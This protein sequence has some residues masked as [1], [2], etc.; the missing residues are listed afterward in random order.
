MRTRIAILSIIISAESVA[1]YAAEKLQINPSAQAQAIEDAR[2][3]VPDTLSLDFSNVKEIYLDEYKILNDFEDGMLCIQDVVTGKCGFLNTE[4]EWAIPVSLQLASF[5]PERT[6]VFRNGYSVLELSQSSQIVVIDQNGQQT[7]LPKSIVQCSDFTPEGYALAVKTFPVDKY[8]SKKKLVFIN[9]QGQEILTG[10]Y[11]GNQYLQ[12]E[13]EISTGYQLEPKPRRDEMIEEGWNSSIVSAYP[14]SDGLSPYYDYISKLWGFF[15]STGK[16]VIPAKYKHV[17]EFSEGLAAVQMPTESD[18]PEKWGFINTADQMVIAPRFSIEP[19]DFSY[20]FARVRKVNKNYVYIDKKGNVVS[21]EYDRANDFY[22]GYAFVRDP[23]TWT[24]CCINTNFEIVNTGDECGLQ[25]D[26]YFWRGRQIKTYSSR[27]G[28]YDFIGRKT[29][30]SD[31]KYKAISGD[32]QNIFITSGPMLEIS[33][34]TFRAYAN[35]NGKVKFA[36]FRNEF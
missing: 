21:P 26:E 25:D 2:K 20:G 16:K 15:D 19:G 10:V 34:N 11:A 29:A 33:T 23:K 18:A 1:L 5:Y 22:Y 36:I 24:N 35:L 13:H 9:P 14:M 8:R 28:R 6:P 27:L 17:H 4:G 32:G 7:M 3:I 31:W 12:D 30:V